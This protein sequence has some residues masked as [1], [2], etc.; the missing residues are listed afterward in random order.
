MSRAAILTA[1]AGTMLLGLT[2]I[3]IALDP[4]TRRLREVCS[5]RDPVL[6]SM[7]RA[8]I[9]AV[10]DRVEEAQR[11]LPR[12]AWAVCIPPDATVRQI[13]ESVDP[14]LQGNTQAAQGR[15]DDVV[16]MA[17]AAA[18]PCR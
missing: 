4:E 18:Y 1:L 3:G 13:L 9:F 12:E 10:L 6:R 5:D 11:R 2:T 7:C 14:F 17:L 15:R 16:A 8:R